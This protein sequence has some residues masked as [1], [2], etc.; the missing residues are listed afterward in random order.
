MIASTLNVVLMIAMR[1]LIEYYG[2]KVGLETNYSVASFV[3]AALPYRYL[4][5]FVYR[6]LV[7]TLMVVI[8]LG[9]K[10]ILYFLIPKY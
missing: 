9:T 7:T 1:N 10:F 8:K 5:V 6:R 4:T 3:I 2:K